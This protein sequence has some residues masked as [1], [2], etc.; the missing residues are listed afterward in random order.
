M[1]VSAGSVATLKGALA[2]TWYPSGM[3]GLEVSGWKVH[4]F[5]SRCSA[6]YAAASR[7]AARCGADESSSTPFLRAICTCG[8]TRQA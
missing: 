5:D 8:G 1:R 7:N 6:A 3:P 2:T 4:W